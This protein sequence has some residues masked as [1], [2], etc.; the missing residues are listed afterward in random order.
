[1]SLPLRLTVA[2]ERDVREARRWY[3][4]EAPHVVPGIRQEIRAT[5]DR[6][7]ERPQL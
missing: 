6:I 5:V 2:A 7:S 1:M 4:K 3:E